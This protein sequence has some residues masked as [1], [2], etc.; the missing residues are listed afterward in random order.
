MSANVEM[1]RDDEYEQFAMAY[2]CVLIAMLQRALKRSRLEPEKVEQAANRFMFELGNF[3]DQGWLKAE[4]QRAYPLLCFTKKFLNVDTDVADVSPVNAP[5]TGFAFH[6][7]AIGLVK[8][9]FEGSED[10][11]VETGSFGDEVSP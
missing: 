8:S 2:Q 10:L 5:S 7:H 4:G 1:V 6:E 11:Q 3:H 9:Y